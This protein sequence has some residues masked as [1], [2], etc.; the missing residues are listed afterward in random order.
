M[1]FYDFAVSLFQLVIALFNGRPQVEGLENLP[2]D[3]PVIIASTHRSLLD[4][5]YLTAVSLPRR[6]AFMAK[7]QLFQNKLFAYIIQ[8]GHVFP[9]NR[10]KPSPKTLRHASN[11]M[12]EEGLNLGI[13]PSGSRYDLEIKSGT[14]FLQRLSKKDI[15][16]VVIHPPKSTLDFFLRRKAKICFGEPILYDEN[17][18]YNKEKL[19]EIDTIIAAAFDKLDAQLDPEYKYIPP[20]KK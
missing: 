6:I 4:P 2:Q 3:R 18:V 13:F 16:P 9:V 7:E 12:N 20:V 1:T 10:D 14:S 17:T 5:V 15:V 19:A 11:V 8:K